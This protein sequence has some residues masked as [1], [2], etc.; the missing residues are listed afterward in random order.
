MIPDTL[1]MIAKIYFVA[2]CAF[3]LWL[4]V[5]SIFQLDR[6]EWKN[7]RKLDAFGVL[8]FQSWDGHYLLFIDR[9]QSSQPE[10]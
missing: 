6:F 3:S 5:L 9:N 1:F 10:L 4:I 7:L 2:G 8:L